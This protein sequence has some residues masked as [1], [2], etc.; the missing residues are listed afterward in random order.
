MAVNWVDYRPTRGSKPM[1]R[2]RG[3]VETD[4]GK[5]TFITRV[6]RPKAMPLTLCVAGHGQSPQ[7]PTFTGA[8]GWRAAGR[9][10]ESAGHGVVMITCGKR[11]NSQCRLPPVSRHP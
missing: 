3:L 5:G 6:A 7:A 10:L 1:L 2:A 9:G 11:A 4:R 8:P